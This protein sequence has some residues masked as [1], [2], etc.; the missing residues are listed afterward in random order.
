MTSLAEILLTT[1][2]PTMVNLILENKSDS[3]FSGNLFPVPLKIVN[4]NRVNNS[5]LLDSGLMLLRVPSPFHL[6][7]LQILSKKFILSS[8]HPIALLHSVT[9]NAS[10]DILIGF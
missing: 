6:I 10:P 9:G 5:K 7:L 4:K 2:S 1:S 3:S 8:I